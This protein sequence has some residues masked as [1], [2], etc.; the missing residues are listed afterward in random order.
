MALVEARKELQRLARQGANET[1]ERA[2]VA[3]LAEKIARLKA[4][5]RF[6]S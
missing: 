1:G 2:Q 3:A 6:R 5:G 4:V